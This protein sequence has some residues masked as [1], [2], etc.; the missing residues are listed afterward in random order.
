MTMLSYSWGKGGSVGYRGVTH[1]GNTTMAS[2]FRDTAKT[3]ASHVFG[4]VCWSHHGCG[5]HTKKGSARRIRDAPQRYLQPYA[6]IP[7]TLLKQPI[8]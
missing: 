4:G 5:Q 6:Q 8:C 2:N 3:G 7:G 1:L